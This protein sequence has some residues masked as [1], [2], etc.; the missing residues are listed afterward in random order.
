MFMIELSVHLLNS[1]YI[2]LNQE[3]SSFANHLFLLVLIYGIAFH[4]MLKMPQILINLSHYIYGG[5]NH[6][7]RQLVTSVYGCGSCE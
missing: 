5:L 7:N 3:Q 1:N 4:I 2:H 6:E